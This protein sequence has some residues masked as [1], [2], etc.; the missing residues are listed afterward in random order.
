MFMLEVLLEGVVL[1][2]EWY[3]GYGICSMRKQFVGR[4][5]NWLVVHLGTSRI[6]L[7]VIGCFWLT[8]YL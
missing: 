3:F 6:P 7:R 2:G 5:F 1:A 4:L 8:A